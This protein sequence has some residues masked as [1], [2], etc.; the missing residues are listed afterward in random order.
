MTSP[1]ISPR[2]LLLDYQELNFDIFLL[3]TKTP[4]VPG[5]EIY[6]A[7]RKWHLNNFLNLPVHIYVHR[8]LNKSTKQSP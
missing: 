5:P 8:V 3:N 7:K 6:G 2:N 4:Q 1:R